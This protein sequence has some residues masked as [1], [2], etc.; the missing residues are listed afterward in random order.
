MFE[1]VPPG[2]LYVLPCELVPCPI[3]LFVSTLSLSLYWS[4]LS[5]GVGI[6]IGERGERSAAFLSSSRLRSVGA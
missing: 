2:V 6:G 4:L 5:V 1:L 3:F